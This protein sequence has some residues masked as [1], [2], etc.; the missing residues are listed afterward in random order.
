MSASLRLLVR[1][2]TAE[3]AGGREFAE[4]VPDHVLVHLDGQELVA[5]VNAK[6]QADELRQDRRA[7]RPDANDLV[8]AGRPRGIGFVQEVSVDC[9]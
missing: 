6:R 4:L 9:E 8:A 2:M 5:V 7:T 3:R 1:G